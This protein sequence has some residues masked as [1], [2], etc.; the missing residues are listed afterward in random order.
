MEIKEIQIGFTNYW[1]ADTEVYAEPL[2]VLVEAGMD[3]HNLALVCNLQLA[4]DDAFGSVSS[5]I[6]GQNLQTF[7]A[8]HSTTT[9]ATT[10]NGKKVLNNQVIEEMIQQKL[11][12]I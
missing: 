8:T 11:Q 9:T 10:T 4:K 6:F 1:A 5:T 12:S 3:E 7:Q 2:S